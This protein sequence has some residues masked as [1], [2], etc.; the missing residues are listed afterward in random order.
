MSLGTK[1]R[2]T[3]PF[4][5]WRMRVSMKRCAIKVPAKVLV[6]E[7]GLQGVPMQ[8]VGF[9]GKAST[10]ESRS[11]ALEDKETSGSYN[12]IRK[13]REKPGELRVPEGRTMLEPLSCC[14]LSVSFSV[15]SSSPAVSSPTIATTGESRRPLLLSSLSLSDTSS[16]SK[17]PRVNFS[18]STRPSSSSFS[19][20][21]VAVS[22]SSCCCEG[23]KWW[24]IKH[25]SKQQENTEVNTGYLL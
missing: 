2:G 24:I 22:L 17:T 18:A 11:N 20:R 5:P 19:L 16:S 3:Y 21:R 1:K 23:D 15:F 6:R 13:Y 8:V 7:Y 12:L 25:L 14:S 4:S 9:R 10:R